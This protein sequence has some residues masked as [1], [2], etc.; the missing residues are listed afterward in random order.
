VLSPEQCG[1]LHLAVSQ[2]LDLDCSFVNFATALVS[3]SGWFF[4]FFFD[5][6]VGCEGGVKSDT[7]RIR[8]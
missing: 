5:W 4:F 3:F 2:C 6:V 7:I 1:L 8:G